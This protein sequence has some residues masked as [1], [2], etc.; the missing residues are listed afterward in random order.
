MDLAD[1]LDFLNG[2]LAR[3][4]ADIISGTDLA[5]LAAVERRLK[6]MGVADVDAARAVAWTASLIP[7]ADRAAFEA[8]FGKSAAASLGM[9]VPPGVLEPIPTLGAHGMGRSNIRVAW[10]QATK[11]ADADVRVI[12]VAL[13]A[14]E[15][16]KTSG[17]DDRK[18]L[19]D[20]VDIAVKHA[21]DEGVRA[22]LS[23]ICDKLAST[24]MAPVEPAADPT[25][26]RLISM[27][28]DLVKSTEA[29]RRLRDLAADDHR[30]N[31]L[32]AEFYAN[33]LQEEDSFYAA[34]F[35]PGIWGHGPPLDWRRL[36]VVKGIGDEL[37]LTYDVTPPDGVEAD[38]AIRQAAVRFISAAMSLTGRTMPCGGTAEDLGPHFDHEAEARQR[39]DH[40]E[41]P[42]KVSLDLVEDAIEISGQRLDHFAN[43][44][45][46]YLSPPQADTGPSRPTAFGAS[47][48]EI[49]RRLNAGHFELAGGHRVRQA[50]RT[51]FIGPHID[52]FFRITKFAL[53]GLVMVGQDLMDVLRFAVRKRYETVQQPTPPEAAEARQE[54]E[55]DEIDLTFPCDPYQSD[56]D[57]AFAEPLLRK[58]TRL[59]AADLKG[60]GAGYAVHHL[61]GIPSF[62]SIV[63]RAHRN[64]FLEDTVATYPDALRVEIAPVASRD[65]SEDDDPL[66]AAS[67]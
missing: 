28:I 60:V 54:P 12:A 18:E 35:A 39:F 57:V 46:D 67:E 21:P 2:E 4:G 23:G 64:P 53:P 32:Y 14:G 42:F 7:G 16:E 65:P 36:F 5:A 26:T 31:Q 66:D 44:A 58:H 27:S 51:D 25:P 6:D 33:F 30:R 56:S 59:V 1:V 48:A 34:L 38:T 41:L 50:Y 45:G 62:R 17:P 49:L 11:H 55:F 24:G 8:A 43:R 52:R 40:M 9:L 10:G 47:H 20:I 19:H 29:K 37:W 13:F 15:A 63:L 61:V 3:H 22:A